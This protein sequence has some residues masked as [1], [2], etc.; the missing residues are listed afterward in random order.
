MFG[1]SSSATRY[2]AGIWITNRSC[3]E[4]SYDMRLTITAKQ[5]GNFGVTTAFWDRV[6]STAVVGTRE[7]R[8]PLF[9]SPIPKQD[10]AQSSQS[11]KAT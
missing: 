1:T 7:R 6:F 11:D 5:D 9:V 8:V 2:I 3:I 10:Y 4:P